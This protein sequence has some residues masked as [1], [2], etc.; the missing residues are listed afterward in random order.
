MQ[1]RRPFV[2]RHRITGTIKHTSG[3]SDEEAGLW[4]VLLTDGSPEASQRAVMEEAGLGIRGSGGQQRRKAPAIRRIRESDTES[5]VAMRFAF[6]EQCPTA[7]NS[8]PSYMRTV[9]MNRWRSLVC[10]LATSDRC[11]AFLAL[12]G[13]EAVGFVNISANTQTKEAEITHL[14]VAPDFRRLGAGRHLLSAA[15]RVGKCFPVGSA[16][17]WVTANNR[18]ARRFYE[19]EGLHPTGEGR[20]LRS[21]NPLKQVKY[22]TPFD[23]SKSANKAD[24]NTHR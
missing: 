8:D 1:L 2:L 24:V 21:G 14:W 20:P 4:E 5:Y 11:A 6:V 22:A 12:S 18:S 23:P 19:S 7:L 10:E 9:P 17:L 15:L 3:L 16:S 13:G